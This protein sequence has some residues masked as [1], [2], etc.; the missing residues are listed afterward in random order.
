MGKLT[1]EMQWKDI[2]LVLQSGSSYYDAA[3]LANAIL[4]F[5]VFLDNAKSSHQINYSAFM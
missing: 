2:S 1:T 3:L 4:L 5:T